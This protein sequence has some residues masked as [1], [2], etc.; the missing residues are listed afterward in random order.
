MYLQ[1][2]QEAEWDVEVYADWGQIRRI[3]GFPRGSR[4]VLVDYTAGYA[5]AD[6]P[7][8]LALAVK[9]LAKHF[10]VRRDEEN[11]GASSYGAGELSVTFEKEPIPKEVK[12]VLDRY[13][14]RPRLT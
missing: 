1:I 14:R 13:R 4:N 10:W 3:G 2:P 11:W 12:D 5:A 6:M 8:D 7:E 9:V